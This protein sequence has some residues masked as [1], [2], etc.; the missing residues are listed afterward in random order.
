VFFTF[1]LIKGTIIPFVCQV[2][3]FAYPPCKNLITRFMF[4]AIDK[5]PHTTVDLI[6][7]R[8]FILFSPVRFNAETVP[9]I[10]ALLLTFSFLQVAISTRFFADSTAFSLILTTL[11]FVNLKLYH[12]TIENCT[13]YKLYHPIIKSINFL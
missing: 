4:C 12:F 1:C 11:V 2:V 8:T 13:A 7:P 10:P 3:T 5:N 6:K 9:S